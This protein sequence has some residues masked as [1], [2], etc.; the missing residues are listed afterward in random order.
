M[1]AR[2]GPPAL[3]LRSRIVGAVLITAMAALAVAAI[4]VLGPIEN[5]LRN[6]ARGTLEADLHGASKPFANLNYSALATSHD[7][8]SDLLRTQQQLA[9]RIGVIGRSLKPL[10]R[11]PKSH[12]NER[13]VLPSST[14][15]QTMILFTAACSTSMT[16]I[17]P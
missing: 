14:V 13:F 6:A 5:S 16:W 4:T 7:T 11:V 10:I 9:Q 17:A 12:S 8:R 2:P 15:P 3:G 1:R